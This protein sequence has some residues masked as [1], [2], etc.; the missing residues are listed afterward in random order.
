MALVTFTPNHQPA[1]A[2]YPSDTNGLLDLLTTGGGLSGTIPD[3]A[4]GG[5]FV[6]STPPSS[7]LTNKVW[8]KT[9]AAGRP[10]GVFMFYNGNWRKVYTGAALGEIR[11]FWYYSGL[12]DG[13]GRGNVGGDMDGWTLCNGQNGA[14]NL[15]AYTAVCGQQGET[16]GGA[17]GVW[18]TDADGTG[19]WKNTGGQKGNVKLTAA[20]LP[21]IVAQTHIVALQGGTTGALYGL[22]TN[23]AA[24]PPY[25]IPIKDENTGQGPSNQPLPYQ[26]L[27]FAVG[28]FMFVGY[29]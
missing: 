23:D 16:V 27:Y 22:A 15:E 11:M 26:N 21:P 28:F 24:S 10:L 3:T 25:D 17:G 12:I 6:G 2:C 7:S 20:N 5:I 9:D 8:F 1:P 4:G 19:A 18:Y 13:T 29:Q 14:P